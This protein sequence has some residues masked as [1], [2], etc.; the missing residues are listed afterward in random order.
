[1]WSAYYV[2]IEAKYMLNINQ[3]SKRIALIK[4]QEKL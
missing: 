3:V 4:Q 2:L 1:M